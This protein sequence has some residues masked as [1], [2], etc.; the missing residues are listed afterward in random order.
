M[1]YILI[2]LVLLFNF[3]NIVICNMFCLNLGYYI[4]IDFV[5]FFFIFFSILIFLILIRLNKFYS[6]NIFISSLILLVIIIFSLINILYFL[7]I[8]ETVSLIIFFFLK[9]YRNYKE[10]NISFIYIFLFNYVSSIPFF[11]LIII[12][13]I[14]FFF[15]YNIVNFFYRSYYFFLVILIF[16]TKLPLYLLHIWLPKAHV[17]SPTIRSI[18]LAGILL[19]LRA[20]GLCRY[21]FVVSNNLYVLLINLGFFR[22]L[23]TSYISIRIVDIKTCIA[24]SSIYHINF[25]LIRLVIYTIYRA[26]YIFLRHALISPLLFYFVRLIYD[27]SN[28]RNLVLL[29]TL[30]K[31]NIILLYI[32]FIVLL[33]NLRLPP[34]INFF[35]EVLIFINLFKFIGIKNLYF[36]LGFIFR[37][38]TIIRLYILIVSRKNFLKIKKIFF[39]DFINI[40]FIIFIYIIISIYFFFT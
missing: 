11:I 35:R 28:S 40:V 10:R 12:I 7:I 1:K 23:F 5:S 37:R 6:I 14:D 4:S 39:I 19:K 36:I 31:T 22:Y 30:F 33:F 38:Y 20:Y 8:F 9:Y 26:L 29:K 2:I 18:I 21:Y 16:T 13:Y 24:Y 25:A 15:N 3:K 34:F 32:Y 17:D 27:F